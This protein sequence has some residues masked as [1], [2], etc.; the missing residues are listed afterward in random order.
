MRDAGLAVIGVLKDLLAHV[1]VMVDCA[2]L[3][4]GLPLVS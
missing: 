3:G 2:P 1:N 4:I